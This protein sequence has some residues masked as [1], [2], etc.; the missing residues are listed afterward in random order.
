MISIAYY[1]LETLFPADNYRHSGGLSHNW[2]AAYLTVVALGYNPIRYH[3]GRASFKLDRRAI[4]SN[5][6]FH[7]KRQS[8]VAILSVM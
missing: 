3:L 4:L 7:R 5:I 8:I 1:D 6:A 2:P